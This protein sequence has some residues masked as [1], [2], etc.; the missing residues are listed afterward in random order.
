[1]NFVMKQTCLSEIVVSRNGGPLR[2][3]ERW[4]YRSEIIDV[5]SVYE[6]MGPLFTPKLSWSLAEKKLS[7]Q[8]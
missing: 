7:F 5:T 1:M 8:T 2:G 4:L 3:Y 6:Y